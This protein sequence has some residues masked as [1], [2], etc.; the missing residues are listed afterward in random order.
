MAA[1]NL[2]MAD[3][4]ILIA[5]RPKIMKRGRYRADYSGAGLSRRQ[6]CVALEAYLSNFLKNEHPRVRRAVGFV[7][8]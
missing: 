1:M 6:I 2:L 8:R 4:T 3:R 7:T 5:R